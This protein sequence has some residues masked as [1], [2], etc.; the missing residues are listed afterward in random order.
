[1]KSFVLLL[2]ALILNAQQCHFET[3][4]ALH[5]KWTAY[6]APGK[7]PVEGTFLAVSSNFEKSASSIVKLL[8]KRRVYIQTRM[9]DTGISERDVKLV[10]FFF[11]L[12]EGQKIQADVLS[13]E[14]NDT[15]GKLLVDIFMNGKTKKIPMQYIYEKEKL[16]AN[17]TIDLADF[18]ALP[19]LRSITISCYDMHQGKTWQ[20][21]AIAFSIDVQKVCK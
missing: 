2:F 8:D 20:D 12:F 5:V 3:D 17:G 9:V 21:V 7:F 4:G 13:V 10:Q 18:N 1:M 16:K 19:G 11:N 6:K 15:E 14:G